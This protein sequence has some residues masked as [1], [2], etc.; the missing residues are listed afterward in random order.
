MFLLLTLA[1]FVLLAISLP[2]HHRRHVRHYPARASQP[3]VARHRLGAAG[4]VAGCVHNRFGWAVGL[5]FWVGGLMVAAFC[6]ALFFTYA[7]NLWGLSS[8]LRH[9]GGDQ[10][11]AATMPSIS[12]VGALVAS[13]NSRSDAGVRLRN[14]SFKLPAMVISLTG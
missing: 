4:A 14:I 3:V 8:G 5:V 7:A 9:I 6:V 1:G 10:T 2:R 11:P 13:L 12:K